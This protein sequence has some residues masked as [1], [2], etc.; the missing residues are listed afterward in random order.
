MT[1]EVRTPAGRAI[2]ERLE[3]FQMSPAELARRASVDADTVTSVLRGRRTP[4]RRTQE[5]IERALDW[6]EGTLRRL[7]SGEVEPAALT[8]VRRRISVGH[9]TDPDAGRVTLELDI[10]LSVWN[11]MSE[12]QRS[13]AL[14]IAS[15]AVLRRVQEIREGKRSGD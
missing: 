4:A 9:S 13:E 14:H 2:L 5:R 10:P 15:A 12:L 3:S 6:P 1:E 11:E 7:L 8:T